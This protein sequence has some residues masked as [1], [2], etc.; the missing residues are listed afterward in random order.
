MARIPGF[1]TVRR[2]YL[3]TRR[4]KKRENDESSWLKDTFL[5]CVS[6]W[7]RPHITFLIDKPGDLVCQICHHSQLALRS[8]AEARG[9]YV[10]LWDSVPAML[11]C[12]HVA[13][14]QCLEIWL[15]DNKSCPFCR[16]KLVHSE[17]GHQV[18]P[19]HL[20]SQ[21]VAFTPNSIPDGGSIP[22]LCYT[23]YKAALWV[24]ANFRYRTC[25]R[26]FEQAR[27]R[28]LASESQAD[29]NILLHRKVDFE[30]VIV[31]EFWEKAITSWL[32]RW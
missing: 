5:P 4:S 26:R 14:A 32:T 7:L 29:A 6:D 28:Y 17:C 27:S 9:L 1:A 22:E 15:W 10:E 18:Q 16:Q 13:G 30:K 11:P 31:E 19:R 20:F 21:N 25:K 8:E 12:G 3:T 23:C 24:S 2:R